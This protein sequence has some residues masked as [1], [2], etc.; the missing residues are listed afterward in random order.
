MLTLGIE[1]SCD[2][3]SAAVVRDGREILANVISSQASLHRRY[4]GVVPEIASRRHLETLLPALEEA[5]QGAGVSLAEIDLLAVTVGPGLL[6]ALLVGVAAAKALAFCRGIP[7][8][9]VNHLAGHIYANFLGESP[10]EFPFLCLVVS[11]GHSD[12]VLVRGHGDFRILGRTRDDAAGEAFDKVA[13]SLGLGYPGGAALDRLAGRGEAGRYS[14]TCARLEPGSLDF[15]FSGIKTAVLRVLKPLDPV[16]LDRQSPHI[17]RSFQESVVEV[18]VEK[19][20]AAALREGVRTVAL[21]G[22]VA[23]NSALRGRMAEAAA[24]LSLGLVYP[25]PVLCTDNAAMIASAGTFLFPLI[26]P[27][28]LDLEASAGLPLESPLRGPR[29]EISQ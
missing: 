10:P 7:L 20:M 18:L 14:F 13:R 26:G 29:P 6:G 19:T 16:E 28:G 3:T 8:V 22:G 11:G 25:S 1:S 2:E 21:A 9:P 5:L 17:A 12:L 15:S 24:R 27:A 4:G 23:A